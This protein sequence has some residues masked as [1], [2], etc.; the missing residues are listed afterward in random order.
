MMIALVLSA[1]TIYCMYSTQCTGFLIW[2][3]LTPPDQLARVCVQLTI[4][5]PPLMQ[6]LKTIR[7]LVL[8]MYVPY[9]GVVVAEE[10]LI[11]FVV[12]LHV[13][14]NDVLYTGRRLD[15]VTHSNPQR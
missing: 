14:I 3:F 11:L 8:Y 7:I 5:I 2:Y 13:A 4:Y 6:K 10:C 15:T 12:F 9:I 1:S